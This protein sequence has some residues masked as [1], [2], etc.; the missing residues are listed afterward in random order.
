M[1]TAGHKTEFEISFLFHFISIQTSGLFKVHLLRFTSFIVKESLLF[2]N[3]KNISRS[4]R[5]A[6][7][8]T[9]V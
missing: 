5:F 4:F 9:F 3:I 6:E 8:Y 2:T 7:T 1:F